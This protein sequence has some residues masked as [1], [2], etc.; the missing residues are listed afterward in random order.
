MDNLAQKAFRG[1][2][3]KVDAIFDLIKN[4]VY[5]ALASGQ[6]HS[7]GDENEDEDVERMKEELAAAVKGLKT[8]HEELLGS[9]AVL[10]DQE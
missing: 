1:L 5:L 6:Q 2:H 8:R 9:V 7:A 10:F 4:D 3:E